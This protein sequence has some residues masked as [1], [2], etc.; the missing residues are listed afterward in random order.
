M[1][2]YQLAKVELEISLIRGL[3]FLHNLDIRYFEFKFC[4]LIEY[5]II[6]IYIFSG[7]F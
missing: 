1:K 7:F 5:N 4:K 2:N 6:Y 3:S